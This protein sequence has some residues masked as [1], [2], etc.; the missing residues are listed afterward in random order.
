MLLAEKFGKRHKAVLRKIENLPKDDFNR[1]NF[2]PRDYV[3]STSRK[4]SIR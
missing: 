3:D 1:R 2:A 4:Y